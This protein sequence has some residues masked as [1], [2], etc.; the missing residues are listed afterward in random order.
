VLSTYG[1]RRGSRNFYPGWGVQLC[2]KNSTLDL[3][4]STT[5][6]KIKQIL[7]PQILILL[8][9]HFQRTITLS[10]I[11]WRW[12][13]EGVLATSI[14]YLSSFSQYIYYG[15]TNEYFFYSTNTMGGGGG[16]EVIFSYFTISILLLRKFR[17][18]DP[19]PPLYPRLGF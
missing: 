16:S 2:Q 14:I 18:A 19:P 11:P 1:L 17:G 9:F 6:I 13:V 10:I 7:S 3:F 5:H 15:V 12:G 4:L 8:T